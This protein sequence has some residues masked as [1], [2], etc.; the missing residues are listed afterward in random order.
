MDAS[1]FPIGDSAITRLWDFGDGFTI[2]S[3]DSLNPIRQYADAG[4]YTISLTVEDLN[5]CTVDHEETLT[6]EEI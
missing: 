6:W 5:G 1:T 2:S 4:T 3:L